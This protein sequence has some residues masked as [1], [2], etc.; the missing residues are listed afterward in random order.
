M[1]YTFDLSS[2]LSNFVGAAL[3]V[4]ID[5]EHSGGTTVFFLL[6]Q[7]ERKVG[8]NEFENKK[9]KNIEREREMN[10]WSDLAHCCEMEVLLEL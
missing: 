9:L 4:H 6:L 5:L 2:A 8:G 10:E 3:A 7:T 1:K